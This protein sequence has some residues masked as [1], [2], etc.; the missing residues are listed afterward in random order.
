MTNGETA[1]RWTVHVAVLRL[2]G[3]CCN[4]LFAYCCIYVALV[5]EE[6]LSVAKFMNLI[7]SKKLEVTSHEV[8]SRK[9]QGRSKKSWCRSR[10]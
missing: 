4:L 9:K 5:K 3:T 10:K 1:N 8:R 2:K 7:G 6:M